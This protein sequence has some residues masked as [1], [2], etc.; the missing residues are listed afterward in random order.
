MAR[1]FDYI[2]VGAGSSGCV[3]ADRLSAD[4][5]HTVL[6]IEAGAKERNPL[7]RM[8]LV[9]GRLNR[10]RMNNWFYHS[11]PQR[12]LNKREIFLPRGKMVG[13]SFIF[14]GMQYVRGHP[15]DYD[16]WASMGL[17]GWSYAE[18]LPYFKRSE[19]YF[20]GANAYHGGD[21]PLPVTREAELNLLSRV[22]LKACAEAGYPS[23][24]DF[25]GPEQEGF[26][27]YDFNLRNGQRWTTARA[28]LY[29][30]L[31]RPNL[32]LQ[33]NAAVTKIVLKDRIAVG[34]EVEQ[35]G[36]RESIMARRETIVA[37]GAIDTP[38]LLMLSGIGDGRELQLLGIDVKC[39]SPGVGK[40][41]IDHAYVA[42]GHKCKEPVSLAG[43][44]R[45]DRLAWAIARGVVARRGP[46]ARSPLEV[47]GFWRS[48]C[49][50]PAP[51]CQF[52]FLPIYGQHVRVWAPWS[53]TL[54]DHNFSLL[55]WAIRPA[56]RGEIRL[57]TPNP[58]EPPVIDPRY[59]T[60]DRDVETTLVGLKAARRLIEQRAFDAYRGAEIAPGSA[61][62]SDE[63]LVG[64]I[65][66]SAISGH[67][68]CGT[69]RMGH[70]NDAVVDDQ[71]RVRG[72]DRLRIADASVT[73]TMPSGNTNAPVIMIAEKASDLILQAA[74]RER[75]VVVS[76]HQSLHE[77]VGPFCSTGWKCQ[78]GFGQ[79]YL[80]K[81]SQW[82]LSNAFSVCRSTAGTAS[83]R[84]C[85]F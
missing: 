10:Y 11:V 55:V 65:R 79:T 23:N 13:G 14:N 21:G 50:L 8:P 72:V 81:E 33:A 64:Y 15:S 63:E 82:T 29:P 9:S 39:N 74:Q 40:N 85:C 52:V 31:K 36:K 18:L 12:K 75:N 22:F 66:G 71:L 51:D 45:L 44:L 27:Q 53:Q 7:Y 24:D 1:T 62:V 30:A 42:V 54:D 58:V 5:R 56:S 78:E 61:V 76:S 49:D 37:A 25:N 4:G 60:D 35:A 17:R 16:A 83:W 77:D 67:H 2:V 26:G 3:L 57:R 38:K 80:G 48:Q 6:L 20:R 59:M 34:V 84:R 41:L 69:A 47:G 68:A 19:S 28:F 46:A 43:T 73:P 32:E 70:D